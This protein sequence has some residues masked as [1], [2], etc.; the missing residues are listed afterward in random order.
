MTVKSINSIDFI[1]KS[2]EELVLDVRSPSEFQHAHFPNANNLPLF[3]DAERKVVG[4]IYKQVSREDAIKTGLDFFGLKMKDIICQVE[5]LTKQRKSKT[6]LIYC[7]R[8]GMRSAAVSWLLDLYGFQVYILKGGYKSYRRW[9]L[10][11]FEKPYHLRVLSGYTGSGK[12][13]ILH[14]LEMLNK[15]II[16]LEGIANHKG[17]TFGALGLPSQPSNEQF[18]NNLAL[19]LHEITQT[20]GNQ[21]IWIESESNRIGNVCNN[22][23]FFN[24]MK[25]AEH[26]HIEV[27]QE[28]RLKKIV[29]EYGNFEKEKLIASV[30]RIKKRLG[31]AETKKVVAYLQQDKV[32][33]AFEILISYYDKLYNS[34]KIF[35]EP[36]LEVQ[37]PD[38]NSYIN[39]QL[40]LKKI[41]EHHV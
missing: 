29:R 15:P 40:I 38:T 18:E 23:K 3:D 32:K 37:L 6:V 27:P 21:S 26:I 36:I 20:K 39:T 2:K 8:G 24:Q 35:K 34:S 5:V 10:E 16:D 12:T 13:E 9:T 11:Q 7:W 25:T 17:S 14:E 22:F 33:E 41:K 19:K 4:T 28:E 31:G 1:E 30:E